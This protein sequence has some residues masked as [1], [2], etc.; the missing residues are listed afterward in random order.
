[1]AN[2]RTFGIAFPFNDSPEGKYLKLT[3]T[4]DDEIRS[5]LI[6]L[7]LTRKGSRYFLPD[8]GTRLYEFIFEPLDNPTFNNIESDIRDACEKYIPNLRITDISITAASSE[9]ETISVTTEGNTINREFSMPNQSQIEYTAKVRIEY[10][11]TDSVFGS[12]DFV[13]INI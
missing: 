11:V 9:E 2:G 10:T 3:Q 13:I 4:S 12:K 5:N 8:F 6:H 1:M 7:L